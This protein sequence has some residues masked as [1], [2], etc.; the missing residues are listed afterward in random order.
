MD[1]SPSFPPQAHLKVFCIEIHEWISLGRGIEI[2]TLPQPSPATIPPPLPPPPLSPAP[3]FYIF[4]VDSLPCFP[5][6][7]LVGRVS[8]SIGSTGTQAPKLQWC[9]QCNIILC[10]SHSLDVLSIFFNQHFS[11]SIFLESHSH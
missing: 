11:V 9:H 5:R 4:I 1:A 2:E 7:K 10:L 6:R 8:S 3:Q